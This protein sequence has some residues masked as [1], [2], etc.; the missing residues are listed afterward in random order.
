MRRTS[1]SSP[2]SKQAHFQ[3]MSY[4][5]TNTSATLSSYRT[6]VFGF[7]G[8]EPSVA[9][10]A[11][12]AGLLDQR[13]A[14]EWARDNVAAFGGDPTRITLFG[15][16]AGST[17]VSTYG[18]A[19][20]SDPIAHGL[21]TQSGTADSFGTP[22][23]DSTASFLA[24]A[25]LLG[26]NSTSTPEGV[27]AAVACIRAQPADA[28]SAAA[29]QVPATTSVLGTFAPTADNTTA[30]SDYDALTEAGAF[31]QIP[32]LHGS[33]SDEGGS[34]ELDFALLGLVLPPAYWEWHTLAFFGCPTAAS[35]EALAHAAPHVPAWR[36]VYAADYPNMRLTENPSLGAYHGSELNP[37]FG[38]SESLGGRDTP[39]EA[40]MGRYMRAAWAAF[41][42]DP[43][44]GLAAKGFGWPVLPAGEACEDEAQLVVLGLGNATGAVFQPSSAWDSACPSVTGVLEALGGMA[45]LLMLAPVLGQAFDGI[46]DGDVIAVGEALLAAAAAATS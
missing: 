14:I 10:V 7:P 43:A 32:R 24:L 31:A 5:V 23:T 4:L 33:N 8:Q 11:P 39:A 6:N 36:Y 3:N 16:S 44:G 18:Y 26:C 45:G 1:S 17:S 34:F 27:S 22:A 35:A 30:F 28:V 15:Q 38:T 12:N 20:A 9:N 13:L 37:L 25:T 46:E 21:I 2:P 42:K 19:Y 40:A 29:A 41:A